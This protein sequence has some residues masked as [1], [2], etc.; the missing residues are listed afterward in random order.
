MDTGITQFPSYPPE[1]SYSGNQLDP[2]TD[3]RGYFSDSPP[4]SPSC[5]LDIL[6]LSSESD[7]CLEV[8]SSISPSSQELAVTDDRQRKKDQQVQ[9]QQEK[10]SFEIGSELRNKFLFKLESINGK[11][12]AIKSS[13]DSETSKIS[14]GNSLYA[15]S[16]DRIRSN[17]NQPT[18]KLTSKGNSGKDPPAPRRDFV[19]EV[20]EQSDSE[21]AA[22]RENT[23]SS[24]FLIPS[25]SHLALRRKLKRQASRALS[26][27]SRERNED[28]SC[29][30]SSNSPRKSPVQTTRKTNHSTRTSKSPRSA[31]TKGSHIWNPKNP[32]VSGPSTGKTREGSASVGEVPKLKLPTLTDSQTKTSTREKHEGTFE[33]RNRKAT[34]PLPPKIHQPNRSSCPVFQKSHLKSPRKSH[35]FAA[36][37]SGQLTHESYSPRM[38]KIKHS[39]WWSLLRNVARSTNT[40]EEDSPGMSR[41]VKNK[42]NEQG[43]RTEDFQTERR[44]ESDK[45]LRRKARRIISFKTTVSA[46]FAQNLPASIPMLITW[47][48]GFNRAYVS[49]VVR[50]CT[51]KPSSL[52]QASRC[53]AESLQASSLLEIQ[54]EKTS[55]TDTNA[56]TSHSVIPSISH[57]ALCRETSNRLPAIS[58][59]EGSKS[60]EHFRQAPPLLI[61]R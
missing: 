28:M 20:K 35:V 50:W 32:R 43:T 14:H 19:S 26:V 22:T 40:H 4:F 51:T 59:Q 57:L 18:E 58:R 29:P 7:D 41:R 21:S 39:Y 11:E 15:H 6:R 54:G 49:R 13:Q 9:Q 5:H 34:V 38:T 53:Q 16:K 42:T 60:I 2:E 23:V 56:L 10:V 61:R 24:H 46:I 45:N 48:N 55:T 1:V 44:T 12:M 8:H 36:R 3:L 31:V 47:S 17:F 33:E 52:L 30:M 37:N 25:S 27:E